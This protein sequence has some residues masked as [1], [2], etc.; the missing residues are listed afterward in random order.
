[1]IREIRA[2]EEI[3]K[4]M[5]SRPVALV[6]V[7]MFLTMCGGVTLIQS[8]FDIRRPEAGPSVAPSIS[9][10]TFSS[11][12]SFGDVLRL[13]SRLTSLIEDVEASL[14]ARSWL[15]RVVRPAI[16]W[17]LFKFSG[18][19]NESVYAGRDGWLFYRPEIEYL[20]GRGF[21]DPQQLRTRSLVGGG[22]NARLQPDSVLGILDF[23]RQLAARGIDLVVL[24]V[25]VKASIHPDHFYA[26]IQAVKPLNNPSFK[27]WISRL[28]AEGVMVVDPSEPL[29]SAARNIHDHGYLATDT[30]WRPAS[31]EFTAD[32]LAEIVTGRFEI[33]RSAV[34]YRRIQETVEQSGDTAI[35]LDLPD[36]KK[37]K[38]ERVEI[39]PVLNHRGEWWQSD[40]HSPVLLLGDSFCNIYSLPSMGWG[41]HAGLA[42]QL[43]FRLGMPVDRIVRNDQGAHATRQLLRRELARGR[44]RLSGKKLVIWQFS[45]R[46]LAVGDWAEIDLTL[47]PAAQASFLR[48]EPGQSLEVTGE[49]LHVSAVP[50][51]GSVPYRDHIL[52]VH[53]V[54]IEDGL[55]HNN[56]RNEALVYLWSMRENILQPAANL[57]NGQSV[58]MRLSAWSDVSGSLDAINRSE[59]QD[60]SILWQEPCW[61]EIMED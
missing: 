37:P 25:P 5:V 2:H 31:M 19:G 47:R 14:E 53:L 49:V 30:H 58:R 6:L 33:G 9:E 51:P 20:T 59:P 61:G 42:E 48:L 32:L 56:E 35:M 11:D 27:A 24:P 21:L 10:H 54:D 12:S 7:C 3:G 43:S 50:R 23:H 22:E 17:I 16:Q 57:R 26:N 55:P 52:S 28:Q 4:T 38:Q 40:P 36:D 15:G 41:G 18:V 8:L 44:D 45:A 13:N 39:H 1:M 46:E 29:F 34:S 60:E